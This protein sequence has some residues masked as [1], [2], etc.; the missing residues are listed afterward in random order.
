MDAVVIITKEILHMITITDKE[1][2]HHRRRRI[3]IVESELVPE[4]PS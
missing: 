2:F 1:L 3:S 4:P